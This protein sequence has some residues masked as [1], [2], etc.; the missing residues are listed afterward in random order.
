[1]STLECDDL[2]DMGTENSASQTEQPARTNV[3]PPFSGK[4]SVDENLKFRNETFKQTI[5]DFFKE[6]YITSLGQL[7]ST[8]AFPTPHVLAQFAFKTYADYKTQETDA[9]YETRLAL[10]DGWKLLTTASNSSRKNG[11]FGAAYWHP[12]HQQV[13]IAHRGTKFT[14]LGAIFADLV[15]VIFKHHVP[16]MVSA[17]TFVHKVIEVLREVNQEKGPIFQVF[18]TGHSLGGWLAQIT[19]FTTK[20]LKMKGNDFLKSEYVSQNF[21]PHTVVFDSPGCKDMLL[22]MTD[23]FDVRLDGRSIDLE[24]LDITSD[25]SA[26]NRINTCNFHAGTV[27][28]I[29]PDL[30][31]MGWWKK[32][33]ALYNKATHSMEKIVEFFDPE[34]GQKH[35]V[36]QCKLKIQVL[37]DWP[38]TVGL[39]RGEEYKSFFKWAKDFNDYHPGVTDEIFQPK[40]YHPIRYQTKIYDERVISVNVFCQQERQFLES[41]RWLRQLPEFFR[42]K[43]LFSEMEDNQAQEQAEKILQCFEIEN[44]RVHCTDA[45][46]LQALIPYVKRLL[47]LFPQ[48]AENTKGVLTPQQIRNNVYR[49]VTKRYVETLRQSPLDFKPD[50]LS[51]RD[52]LNTN[53]QRVLQL[54]MIDG[55]AWTGLIKV[56]QLLEKTPSMTD[57]LSEGHY[58]ILT[59][60]HLILVNQLVNLNTLLQST[61][62]PHLLM[63]SCET[64]QPL[65]VESEQIL[66]SLFNA[67]RQK[68]SVKIIFTTQSEGNTVTF[69]QDIAKETLSGGFLTRDEQLTWSDLTPS[70]QEKLLQKR[71]KFQGA[72]ISLNELMSA[73]SPAASFLPLGALL[74][75]KELAIADPVPIANTYNESYYIGRTLRHQKDIK[76]NVFD[77]ESR[78]YSPDLIASTDQGFKQSNELKI[79]RYFRRLEYK[80]GRRLWQQSQGSLEKLRRYNDTEISH[81]YTADDLDKLLEQAQ[82]QRVML[83]SDVAGMG[84][85]TFLTHLSTQIKQKFPTKWVVRLD[86]NDHTDALE[87]LKKG[88]EEINKEKAIEFVSE[89]LLKLKPDLEV[90]FF[91]QCCEQKQKVSIVIMLDGFDEI[92]PYTKRLSLIYCKP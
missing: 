86:L 41:Y 69:L 56:Y 42:L 36:Q 48:L 29:F 39:P 85:S 26:P 33:T 53:E 23:K 80:S 65:N 62:E 82:Q 12:E 3:L 87:A 5:D 90:E 73:G 79:K 21:H 61:T 1:M 6:K 63:V 2:Q 57:R 89:K 37:A 10:P 74:E 83:I 28:R 75:E 76:E 38:V 9:Q 27:Y 51:I 4:L 78:K 52:F 47:E 46:E 19:T 60:D 15:G 25:L 50:A 67:L 24:H 32:H 11:Y 43:E 7:T 30:S 71:V 31:D 13:V 18:F 59:L 92:S 49:F 17:S 34:K 81:T 55:H 72:T 45:S 66:K 22:Q 14:N 40:D 54:R 8:P 64:N 58:T 88:K 77:D 44:D 16:Q 68:L 91:K 35:K 20:Y 70:S 84:K